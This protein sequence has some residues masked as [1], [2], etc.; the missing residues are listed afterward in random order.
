MP[1]TQERSATPSPE[2]PSEL[3]ATTIAEI[4]RATERDRLRAFVSAD[5][6]VLERLHT[7]DFQL[8]NP[9]GRTLTKAEYLG[10]VA[11]GDIAYLV[12]APSSAMDVRLYDE[13]AAVRDQ[14]HTEIV[15]F[16]ETFV[17][18]NWHP[19]VYEWRDERWQVV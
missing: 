11:A 8:I 14:S 2:P 19:D 10:G 4:I 9:G 1:V 5:I 3:T 7:D 12:W 15:D 17:I 18:D 13:A 16:G 6:P